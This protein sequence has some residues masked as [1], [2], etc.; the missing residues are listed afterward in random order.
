M[1]A[2]QVAGEIEETGKDSLRTT[3]SSI[4]K[5]VQELRDIP[6][7]VT[8]VTEKLLDDRNLTTLK[9]SL[10]Q[11]GG[12]TFLAA[13]GGEEDIRLRG[14]SLQGSGDIFIDGMRDPAFY[15]RDSFNWDRL[16]SPARFG[17]DAVRPRFDRRRGQPGRPSIRSLVDDFSEISLTGGSG[18]N[19][20]SLHRR[21]EL[22]KLGET[23]CAIRLN[24]DVEP[25]PRA[26]ATVNRHR[27]ARHRTDHRLRF[28]IGT[29]R[30]RS[31]SASYYAD[32][33]TTASTTACPG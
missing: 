10:K 15:D 5:G 33:T 1:E 20:P 14:F 24:G 30:R 17:L 2:I 27:E 16:E 26:T 18:T 28:G 6:Q 21:H 25:L 8:V 4:G 11:A 9:D 22:Q 32:A 31:R 23:T 12:V 29:R 7:S 19:V 3:T 13:E